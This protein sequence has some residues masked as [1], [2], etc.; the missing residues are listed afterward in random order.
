MYERSL[1][2]TLLVIDV[3]VVPLDSGKLFAYLYALYS[4]TKRF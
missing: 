3:K 1:R 2:E 4:G